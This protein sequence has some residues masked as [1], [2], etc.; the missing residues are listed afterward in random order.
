MNPPSWKS[1]PKNEGAGW[2][3][4]EHYPGSDEVGG[5]E[6]SVGAWRPDPVNKSAGNISLECNILQS[7]FPMRL[8][9]LAQI[10][11]FIDPR[12]FG[13]VKIPACTAN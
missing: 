10:Y 3:D 4:W 8:T 1:D 12:S 9:I 2:W 6:G 5:L 13:H 11:T 7:D